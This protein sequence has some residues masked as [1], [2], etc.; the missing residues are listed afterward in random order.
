MES[1]ILVSLNAPPITQSEQYGME[2]PHRQSPNVFLI[3][4]AQAGI[5]QTTMSNCVYSHV[6]RVNLK[7]VRIV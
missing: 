5:M 4:P 2:T 1:Q 3:Q 6:H 7:M